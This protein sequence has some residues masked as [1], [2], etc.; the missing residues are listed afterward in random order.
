[1]IPQARCRSSVELTAA[2]EGADGRW[3]VNN[4]DV[5]DMVVDGLNV[6]KGKS[7]P[8]RMVVDLAQLRAA[9]ATISAFYNHEALIGHWSDIEISPKGVVQTLR[10]TRPANEIEAQV[11]AEAVMV[12]AHLRAKV[13]WQASIGARP[14]PAGRWEQIEAGQSVDVN[15]RS[16]SG[17]GDAPLYVLRGGELFET[18][19]CE[20]G[21]DEKT[22]Q[23]AAKKT[24]TTDPTTKE[25]DMSRMKLLASLS[26]GKSPAMCAAIIALC[27][28]ES[29]PD[30]EIGPKVTA[31]E[32]DDLKCRLT[33]A[34]EGSKKKDETIAALQAQMAAKAKAAEET[35]PPADDK[36]D[37]AK[38]KAAAASSKKGVEFAEGTTTGDAVIPKTRLA[39]QAAI[40]AKNPKLIGFGVVTAARRE[41][42]NYD[43]LP[44]A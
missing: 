18:S 15:G 44:I 24:T 7:Q 40:K 29:V 34:E 9:R 43:D 37:D 20:F 6:V 8:I 2:V 17:D 28:D 41:F 26:K 39:A 13:P 10:L 36:K 23:I 27:A 38:A 5:M 35:A 3:L 11:L 30:A 14:G 25:S 12:G 42:K 22:G 33:A 19:V 16:F 21:A 1:M 32:M 31:L 4:G